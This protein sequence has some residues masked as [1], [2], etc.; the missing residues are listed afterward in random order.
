MFDD[1]MKPGDLVE[2]IAESMVSYKVLPSGRLLDGNELLF[3]YDGMLVQDILDNYFVPSNARLDLISSNFRHGSVFHCDNDYFNYDIVSKTMS[4]TSMSISNEMEEFRENYGS[5]LR[6]TISNNI[7]RN[8]TNSTLTLSQIL[9]SD[10]NS[11][12]FPLGPSQIEPMF[13]TQFWSHP[14]PNIFT[15]NWVELVKPQLPSFHLQSSLSLPPRN[16]FIP[17]CYDIKSISLNSE[18]T[19]PLVNISITIC[20]LIGK[21]KIWRLAT[22]LQYNEKLNKILLSTQGEDDRWHILDNSITPC[23]TT[24]P[25]FEGTVDQK[26]IKFKVLLHPEKEQRDTNYNKSNVV[27]T[28]HVPSI[29]PSAPKSFLPDL[30]LD[31]QVFKLWY[32]Q[33]RKFKRPIAELRLNIICTDI[34]K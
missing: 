15:N 32:L 22:I 17:E 16:P 24:T 23:D 7:E 20:S 25:N 29:P 8:I 30:I 6:S 9:S 4:Q 12:A 3:T 26:E 33:D 18:I 11:H 34:N 5:R 19:H 1:E 28:C 31:S 27:N 2:Y 10:F 14:I 13:G 21:E